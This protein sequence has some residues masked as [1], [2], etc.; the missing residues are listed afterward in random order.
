M[1]LLLRG[2]TATLAL[3]VAAASLLGCS[4]PGDAEPVAS[5]VTA[6]P[7]SEWESPPRQALSAYVTKSATGVPLVAPPMV[8]GDTIAVWVAADVLLGEVQPLAPELV[9]LRQQVVAYF[10]KHVQSI[11]QGTNTDR[12]QLGVLADAI[13][14]ASAAGVDVDVVPG[15]RPWLSALADLAVQ[16]LGSPAP[17]DDYGAL[18]LR[19]ALLQLG[20]PTIDDRLAGWNM[21]REFLCA[22]WSTVAPDAPDALA[23]I[24]YDILHDDAPCLGDVASTLRALETTDAPDADPHLIARVLQQAGQWERGLAGAVLD[25]ADVARYAEEFNERPGAETLVRLAV[26]ADAVGLDPATSSSVA[27]AL[28]RIVLTGGWVPDSVDGPPEID[29]VLFTELDRAR[30]IE[31]PPDL[32]AEQL[33]LSLPGASPGEKLAALVAQVTGV[34]PP[35]EAPCSSG[36]PVAAIDPR[37]SPAALLALAVSVVSSEPCGAPLDTVASELAGTPGVDGLPADWVTWAVAYSGCRTS[38]TEP[39]RRWVRDAAPPASGEFDR[40]DPTAT[41]LQ[42][43]DAYVTEWIGSMAAGELDCETGSMWT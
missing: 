23:L 16:E 30:A 20:D 3:V 15:V 10:A 11:G 36:E 33:L 8:R 6:R 13:F 27:P 37:T 41:S 24:G 21:T 14:Y 28:T 17:V 4:M 35:L 31:A 9:P 42:F 25:A 1:V 43:F 29:A 22:A 32:G 39:V 40:T 38:G 7:A 2:G 34:A 26:A 12:T 5:E 19:Q 18:R